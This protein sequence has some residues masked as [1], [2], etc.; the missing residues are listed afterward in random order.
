[1]DAYFNGLFGLWYLSFPYLILYIVG[2]GGLIY[3]IRQYSVYKQAQ[4]RIAKTKAH[5]L[6]VNRRS[7]FKRENLAAKVSY[8]VDDVRYAP[9]HFI[10][11]PSG[12][13]YGRTVDV[14]YYIDEPGKLFTI[15][16]GDI[17][18]GLGWFV[19]CLILFLVLAVG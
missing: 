14:W 8:K 3:A 11:V 16:K 18:Q 7:I 6:S 1:M 19:I 10:Q 9:E 4:G 2:I 12:T 15:T 13:T 5:V 17:Y